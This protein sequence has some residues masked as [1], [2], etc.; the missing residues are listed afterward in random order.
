MTMRCDEDAHIAEYCVRSSSDAD[1]PKENREQQSPPPI[2]KGVV[3]QIGSSETDQGCMRALQDI[4]ERVM[5]LRDVVL[6]PTCQLYYDYLG[7]HNRNL[8]GERS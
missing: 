3:L 8:Y 6:T 2:W 7:P 4:E 5:M 1:G